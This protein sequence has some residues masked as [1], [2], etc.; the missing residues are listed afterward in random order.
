VA[1]RVRL[2]R[3]KTMARHAGRTVLVVT[4]VTPI[5]QL[6]RLALDAPST[7]L[8]R[9]ELAAASLTVVQW[10]ADG[11]ASLKLFNDTSHLS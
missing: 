6:V 10:Y 3:D 7:A 1:A 11:N 5:K 9:M 2:A 8:F 4:H